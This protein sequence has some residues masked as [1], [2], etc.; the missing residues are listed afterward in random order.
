MGLKKVDL[1]KM[2]YLK[3]CQTES[4]R[5]L[6]ATFGSGRCTSQPMVLG[7][8]EIPVGTVVGDSVGGFVGEV[9]GDSVVYS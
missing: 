2:K 6:P 9:V 5:I 1:E 8:Y 3:A 4:Q 7:G